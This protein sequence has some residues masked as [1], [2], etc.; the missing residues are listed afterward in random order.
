MTDPDAFLATLCG[1]FWS[2]GGLLVIVTPDIGSLA[3]SLMGGRW[4][5]YRVA[6]INFFNRRSLERLLAAHGFEIV[7]RKRFAWNFSALL[8]ADT[9]A[10]V[11]EG[12]GFTK[13]VEERYT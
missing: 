9:A 4:W 11:P 13:A 6:H 12:Q 3:A 2:P 7:L 1:R 5:H 8:P 10:A